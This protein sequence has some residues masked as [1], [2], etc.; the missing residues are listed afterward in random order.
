MNFS[1]STTHRMAVAHMKDVVREGEQRR[2]VRVVRPHPNRS[3]WGR[4]IARVLESLLVTLHGSW[5]NY[6]STSDEVK[7]TKHCTDEILRQTN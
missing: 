1:V 2:L 3:S 6:D 7:Q 5:R 4:V